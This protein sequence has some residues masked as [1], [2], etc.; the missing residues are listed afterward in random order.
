[1]L[2]NTGKGQ[3]KVDY[4]IS[5]E[6]SNPFNPSSRLYVQHILQ[7]HSTS[8]FDKVNN[9]AVVYFCGLKN[10]MPEILNTLESV[11]IEKGLD[12]DM[13]LKEWKDN[14]QWHVEVY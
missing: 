9:G 11:A 5:R 8:F 1:M 13:K 14:G 2:L 12:W 3:L 4:A 6:M 7:Q 10:M